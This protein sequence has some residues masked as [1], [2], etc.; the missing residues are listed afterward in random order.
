MRNSKTILS[1]EDKS[2]EEKNSSAPR[3]TGC[4]HKMI[5]PTLGWLTKICLYL[6]RQFS[7]AAIFLLCQGPSLSRCVIIY[8]GEVFS[9]WIDSVGWR[10]PVSSAS[11]SQ[12]SQ[13]EPDAFVPTYSLCSCPKTERGEHE[14]PPSREECETLLEGKIGPSISL[15][16]SPQLVHC[17]QRQQ[18]GG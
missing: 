11:S 15:V 1:L 10:L 8:C 2:T 16:P 5:K 17:S 14:K 13:T 18:T 4:L 3:G 6:P 12:T 7:H 9:W